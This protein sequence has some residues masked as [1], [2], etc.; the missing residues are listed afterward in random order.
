MRKMT[1]LWLL[2]GLCACEKEESV[3]EVIPPADPGQL[4]V[5][6]TKSQIKLVLEGGSDRLRWPY[7]SKNVLFY[8][9]IGNIYFDRAANP[10][11]CFDLGEVT[12]FSEI[13]QQG[14][15]EENGVRGGTH[16]VAVG[17]GYLLSLSDPRR[18]PSGTEAYDA[19][20]TMAV[21]IKTRSEQQGYELYYVP[22]F[23]PGELRYGYVVTVPD[24]IVRLYL[25]DNVEEWTVEE[26]DGAAIDV[27]PNGRFLDIRL[28]AS[29]D[30]ALIQGCIWMR[31]GRTCAPVFVEYER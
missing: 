6:Y 3:V 19:V 8:D 15:P 23:N 4:T 25:P 24:R 31:S 20:E 13:R 14:F 11:T 21:W 28:L 7:R 12:N 10:F 29:N 17:H 5:A 16:P 22:R 9:L 27:T 2:L 18:F 30:T 1:F 26:V